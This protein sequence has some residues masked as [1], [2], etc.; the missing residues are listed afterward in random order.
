MA[1]KKKSKVKVKKEIEEKAELET[2][3]TASAS[4]KEKINQM[5]PTAVNYYKQKHLKKNQ[6]KQSFIKKRNFKT[7]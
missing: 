5:Q 3:P 6:R 4:I 7:R 2:L 1:Q